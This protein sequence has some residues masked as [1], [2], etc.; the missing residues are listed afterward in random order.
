MGNMSLPTTQPEKI[1]WQGHRKLLII[2]RKTTENRNP[3]GSWKNSYAIKEIKFH[4]NQIR[5]KIWTTDTFWQLQENY[6]RDPPPTWTILCKQWLTA[7][8]NR[9]SKNFYASSLQYCNFA[10]QDSFWSKISVTRVARMK[11][12]MVF[13]AKIVLQETYQIPF[14]SHS[15]VLSTKRQ[16]PPPLNSSYMKSS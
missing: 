6:M 3:I 10:R 14:L 2:R 8:E 11:W 9:E 16:R 7:D 1:G 15:E 5:Y 13:C 12:L 4:M